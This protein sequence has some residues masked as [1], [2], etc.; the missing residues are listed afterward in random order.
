MTETKAALHEAVDRLEDVEAEALLKAIRAK[1]TDTI[2][3]NVE[4]VEPDEWDRE[5]IAEI[6]PQHFRET[7]ST[8]D[9]KRELGI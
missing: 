2:L 8:D 5:I 1:R 7:L 3:A 6:T 4:E 9:V